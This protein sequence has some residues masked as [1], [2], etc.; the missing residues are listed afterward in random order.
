MKR[1]V[2][3]LFL[4]AV[5]FLAAAAQPAQ[6]LVQETSE[7][8]L[9]TLKAE[10]EAIQKNPD[11]LYELVRE[12]VLPHFDFEQMSRLVLGKNWRKATPEQ[13]ERFVQEFQILLV[14]TYGTAL[15]EYR[16]EK[17]VY[18]PLRQ[19][20]DAKEV[21]VRTEVQRTGAPPIPIDYSMVLE[22]GQWKVYDVTIE[23]V[24]LVLNYR[25]S[26]ASE[27]RQGGFDLLLK[28]LIERNQK[29]VTQSPA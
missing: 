15:N 10:R 19:Q 12:I 2:V 26:F 14:R 9:A 7:R 27:I 21:T 23:G 11:R 25:T 17:I 29:P 20:P 13:R 3:T 24:S 4:S 18:L 6:Q 5:S 16:D 22:D 1:F 28:K 8:M